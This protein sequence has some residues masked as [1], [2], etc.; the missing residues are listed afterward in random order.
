MKKET[1]QLLLRITGVAAAIT[2]AI[3]GAYFGASKLPPAL[4]ANTDDN[5]AQVII[6]DAGHGECA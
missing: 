4:P 3:G 2:A 1:K 5:A 6:L